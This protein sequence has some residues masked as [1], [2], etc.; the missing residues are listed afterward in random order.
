VERW[1][2]RIAD[3]RRSCLYHFTVADNLKSILEHGLC[4][5]NHLDGSGIRYFAS[6]KLRKDGRTDRVSLSYCQTNS[7]YLKKL[8][9][10]FPDKNFIRISLRA[11]IML[12]EQF[13]CLFFPCNAASSCF[14]GLPESE[15]RG[16]VG[17][18]RFFEQDEAIKSGFLFSKK[19]REIMALG[20]IPVDQFSSVS[21]SS[22]EIFLK[23]TEILGSM[24]ISA[25][26]SSFGTCDWLELNTR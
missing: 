22:R 6:D 10:R 24:S 4:S 19:Q 5:R 7:F 17:I 18:R 26:I 21:F 11:S 15:F 16:V 23:F 14:S 20:P 2:Q 8:V 12:Q 1:L 25:N 3:D 13:K 9:N